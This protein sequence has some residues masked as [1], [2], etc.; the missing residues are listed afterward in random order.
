MRQ[1]T[2]KVVGDQPRGK[3]EGSHLKTRSD[4]GEGRGPREQRDSLP[5][6]APGLEGSHTGTTLSIYLNSR[7]SGVLA[8][9]QMD[10]LGRGGRG[11][12]RLKLQGREAGRAG[13]LTHSGHGIEK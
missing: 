4:H 13:C 9:D 6:G 7:D 3:A 8:R 10:P 2:G 12:H 11:K 5:L 1:G